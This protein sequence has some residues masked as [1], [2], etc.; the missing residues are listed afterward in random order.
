MS[1]TLFGNIVCHP[2]M[3]TC[4]KEFHKIQPLGTN[5]MKKDILIK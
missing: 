5:K 4:A 1:K 3:N 2:I